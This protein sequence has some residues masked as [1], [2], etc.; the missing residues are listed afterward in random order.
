MSGIV[1][2]VKRLYPDQAKGEPSAKR[3]HTAPDFRLGDGCMGIDTATSASVQAGNGDRDY[4]YAM[5]DNEQM[6]VDFFAIDGRAEQFLAW[7]DCSGIDVSNRLAVNELFSRI[8]SLPLSRRRN[9]FSA[10]DE[11][12]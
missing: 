7:I 4:V 12:F 11:P 5:F 10:P 2:G 6:V 9:R 1:G 8:S 3:L